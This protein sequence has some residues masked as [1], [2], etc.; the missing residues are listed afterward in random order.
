MAQ[1]NGST[2][3]DMLPKSGEVSFTLK[4]KTSSIKMSSELCTYHM[5]SV[6]MC[7]HRQVDKYKLLLEKSAEI[8]T[9]L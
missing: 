5:A 6:S 9:D 2:D 8:V 4:E 7:A 3:N 1:E